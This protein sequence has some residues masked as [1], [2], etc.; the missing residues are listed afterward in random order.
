MM[1][2]PQQIRAAR[3][4]LEWS[5]ETL[6][7][8]AGLSLATIYNLEKGHQS[9]RSSQGIRKAFENK[10]FEFSGTNGVSRRLEEHTNYGGPEGADKFYEDLLAT[11]R[12]QDSDIVAMFASQE[13]FAKALGVDPMGSLSRLEELSK[14]ARI[15][16]LLWD[17]RK[18]GLFIP[19]FEFRAA[20]TKR[21]LSP[22]SL[23][24]YGRKTALIAFDNDF[25]YFVMTS[26]VIA[27]DT[28]KDF[29]IDWDA[30]LPIVGMSP[31]R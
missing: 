24:S 30:A 2:S 5:Q 9:L 7:Q 10:G 17:I 4:M 26:A 21:K 14:Q 13:D 3:A 12:D 29:M 25:T 1:I 20:T 16:C 22:F 23:V 19:Y 27:N 6:A 8:E 18:S 31:A 28:V 11:A 15:K